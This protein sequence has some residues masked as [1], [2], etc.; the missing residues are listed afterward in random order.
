[1]LVSAGPEV[2]PQH[3]LTEGDGCPFCY[4]IFFI[5]LPYFY[6]YSTALIK[7]IKGFQIFAKDA[8]Y[9]MQCVTNSHFLRTCLLM[10]SF[11]RVVWVQKAIVPVTCCRSDTYTVAYSI[12]KNPNFG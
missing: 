5:I 11:S 12:S 10:E 9:H 7:I 2:H 8:P 4:N 6:C 1:M 3:V